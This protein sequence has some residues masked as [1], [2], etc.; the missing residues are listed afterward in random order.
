MSGMKNITWNK[1]KTTVKGWR[2]GDYIRQ[3]SIVVIGV[4]ITFAGSELVTQNSE[5]KDIRATMSLIRD[6]LK[7][8]RENYE[9]IVS[10]FREDEHLSCLLVEHDLKHRTIP[11]DSLIQFR[12][13]MG[14]IRNFYYSQNALDILKSSMLMQKISDKELLLQLTGI[15]EVLDGFKATMNGY[16]DMKDEIT[17]PFHLALTDEQTDQLNSGGYE[18][19][20]IYLSDKSVRNF[21]RI[22]KNYFT[23]DY[24]ERV[25]KRID[26][27]IQMLEERYDLK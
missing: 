8:N 22:A 6:E 3:T 7:S 4:V 11:E 21:V 2:L 20:D 9:S 24:V 12:F 27:V 10:E 19:W 16:Y 14:H 18:A 25:G 13:L 23:P 17:L 26:E 1:V 15:Y 5:R